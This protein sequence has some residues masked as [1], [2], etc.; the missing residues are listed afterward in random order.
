[1]DLNNIVVDE[2]HVEIGKHGLSNMNY[3]KTNQPILYLGDH[4]IQLH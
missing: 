4:G 1:M 2:C 3:A